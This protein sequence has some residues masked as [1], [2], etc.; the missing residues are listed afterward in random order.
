MWSF[1]YINKYTVDPWTTDLNCSSPLKHRFFYKHSTVNVF[2]PPKDFIKLF[3]RE[4]ECTHVCTQGEG[5]D[6]EG[7]K[8]L[9]RFH[10]E[11]WIWW[12]A[13]SQNSEIR[14]W[15]ETGSDA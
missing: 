14:T 3:D 7:E 5:A 15:A 13:P 6:R 10:T 8:V 2:Y 11:G 12:V 9:S 4:R 1:F